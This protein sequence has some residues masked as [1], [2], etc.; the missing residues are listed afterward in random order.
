VATAS[1]F[2]FAVAAPASA[3]DSDCVP[4][5]AWT[6]TIPGAGEPTIVVENPDFV[7]GTPAKYRV[8][9]HEAVTRTVTE[10]QRYSWNPKGQV[11][12][13]ET[14]DVTGSTPLND[15]DHWNANTQNYLN[16]HAGEPL[17]EVFAMS[18]D[19]G[20]PDGSWFYWQ[21]TET[22]V[23]VEEAWDERVLCKEGTADQGEPWIEVDNP[24]YVAPVVINHPPVV[25][26]VDEEEDLASTGFDARTWA[27]VAAALALLGTAG[28]LVTRRHLATR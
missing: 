16:G 28:V 6:E 4:Q 15:A 18:D 24:D 25:C 19:N 17:N 26:E 1:A 2:L 27:L 9:H 22:I 10:Y 23:V 12:E 13:G 11:A 3:S 7:P 21:T 8:V 5:D 20:Q 14:P